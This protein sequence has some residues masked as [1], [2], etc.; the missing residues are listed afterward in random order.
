MGISYS[1]YEDID[2]YDDQY[3]EHGHEELG[4]EISDL[5]TFSHEQSNG[6]EYGMYTN[7]TRVRV[8]SLC[9][10]SFLSHV[11]ACMYHV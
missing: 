7:Y 3:T 9:F 11:H 5:A 2:P 6:W 4:I 1:E 8:C 10:Y